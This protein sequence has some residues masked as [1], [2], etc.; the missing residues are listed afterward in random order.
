MLNYSINNE[1]GGSA[2]FLPVSHHK[3]IFGG[4]EVMAENTIPSVSPES[5]TTKKCTKC[6][7]EKPLS[8]FYAMAISNDGL[9]WS[10]K[11][12]AAKS[13][14]QWRAANKDKLRESK[15]AYWEK[16]RERLIPQHTEWYKANIEQV[17]ARGVEYRALHREDARVNSVAWRAANVERSRATVK[18]WRA[19]NPENVKK[20]LNAWKVA[21]PGAKR[22]Y[23]QNREARKREGGKLSK[24]IVKILFKRQ[25]GRC[26][27][28]GEGLG[29][30]YQLDHIMPIALGGANIDSNMQ[31]LRKR[32]N[33]QK[34]KKHPIDFMQERGF[35]L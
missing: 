22:V 35:L 1:T 30:D 17:K 9:A 2:N 5:Q 23:E 15:A 24:E 12:C 3:P 32:C 29:K 34:N 14:A 11:A 25:R 7:E 8:E 13:N 31:L 4:Y 33:L 28:C 21:N 20:I 27:C 16:N 26:A 19:A 10:C 6:G 18:A